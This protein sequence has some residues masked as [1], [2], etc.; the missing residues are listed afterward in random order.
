MTAAEVAFAGVSEQ[1]RLIATRALSAREVVE[2]C[3]NRIELLDGRVNAWRV[4][5]AAEALREADRID[6]ETVADAD[7]P[8][9]GVPVGVKDDTDVAGTVTAWGT[10]AHGSVR[11]R[12][13]ELVVRLRRAGAIIIGKT[14][15]PELTCWPFTDSRTFGVT[16]NPWNLDRTPGGSSGGSAAAVAAGMVGGATGSDSAGSIRIPAAW[17]GLVGFKPTHGLVPSAPREGAWY[18]LFDNGFLTRSVA[19]QRVLLEA[20]C[21]DLPAP[22]P[23]VPPTRRL[24]IGW[25]TRTLSRAFMGGDLD[26]V[27]AAGLQR[28]VQLLTDLGHDCIQRDPAYGSTA[29]MQ[30]VARAYRGIHEDVATLP[31]RD[32]LEPRTRAAARFGGAIPSAAARRFRDRRGAL[33][34]RVWSTLDD[35]D[36]LLVPA[37]A[38]LAPDAARWQHAGLARI[39]ADAARHVPYTMIFNAT[40]DPACAV[41]CG[42]SAEGLP[43]A[44]QLVA[45]VGGDDLLLRLAEQIEAAQPWAGRRPSCCDAT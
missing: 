20:V 30:F 5:L 4:V 39:F 17:C 22:G 42:F 32:R 9:R 31:G 19:D 23:A 15:V 3:L 27:T 8:L 24:R 41:P 13:A 21:H 40:G 43:V 16:R 34:R 33:R 10:S 11:A 36:V 18:E 7:L 2:A 29:L 25:S 44:V 6:G 35:I 45:R 26:A 38:R 28:T 37:T 12:D 1:A 14:H